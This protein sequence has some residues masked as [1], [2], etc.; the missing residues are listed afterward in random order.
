[1]KKI[2]VIAVF[3]TFALMLMGL[4]ILVMFWILNGFPQTIPP[5]WN[6]MLAIPLLLFLTSAVVL[7]VLNHSIIVSEIKLLIKQIN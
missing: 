3:A 6:M 2:S 7:F 1:M 4:F 5:L